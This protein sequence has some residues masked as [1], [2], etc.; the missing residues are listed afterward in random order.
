MQGYPCTER[1]SIAQCVDHPGDME[2][3][4]THMQFFSEVD[5][6]VC[7]ADPPAV[8]PDTFGLR[9]PESAVHP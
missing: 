9:V 1:M 3:F 7:A 2:F 5:R 4:H 6:C 8:S